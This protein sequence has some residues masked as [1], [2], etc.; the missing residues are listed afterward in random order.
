MPRAAVAVEPLNHR[1]RSVAE[2]IHRVQRVAYEQ[3][4]QLL[5]VSEFPLLKRTVADVQASAEQFFG[6]FLDGT[7]VGVVAVEP[8][9]DRPTLCISSLVVAPT[10][11]R[12]GIGSALLREMLHRSASIAVVVS[13]ASANARALAL[14]R[15]F[16]FTEI[17][18]GFAGTLELVQLG[19]SS[20]PS[21]VRVGGVDKRELLQMLRQHNV[22]LNKAAK[23][24]FDDRRFTP[25]T[26]SKVIDI[27]FVSVADLGFG[28]GSTYE[29]LTARALESGLVE[30]PLELGPHLRVQFLDQPEGSSGVPATQHRAPPGSV[31]IASS[32]LDDRDETPKGF[33]LRRVDGTL[34]LRGYR[35]SPGHIWAPQDVLVFS[36]GRSAA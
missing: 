27:A 13:T 11:Q 15:Q 35:S 3:E 8:S 24:L 9:E 18:R 26:Q 2:R 34:W 33:Y 28:E 12:S 1:E 30:C 32:P 7:L 25:L 22:Q 36:R 31:T 4:A 23:V 19:W 16:G 6:A 21:A 5:G 20:A 14:Y 17:G 29:Q 10:A